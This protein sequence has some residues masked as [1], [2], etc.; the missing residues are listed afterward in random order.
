MLANAERTPSERR[1][2]AER[3]PSE[4]QA[5]QGKRTYESIAAM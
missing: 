4:R 1:A 5:K 3:T 2:N